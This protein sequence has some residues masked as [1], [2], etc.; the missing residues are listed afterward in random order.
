MAYD[1][2]SLDKKAKILPGVVPYFGLRLKANLLLFS[3][4]PD[5]LLGSFSRIF[6]S[7]IWFFLYWI[8]H[9]FYVFIICMPKIL[10]KLFFFPCSE[11]KVL[12]LSQES[13]HIIILGFSS[14]IIT[15][16]NIRGEFK[17]KTVSMA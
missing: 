12:K 15:A 9:C 11:G 8:S 13:I 3:P 1:V 7:F 4:K 17:Y 2:I 10:S 16:D 14:A 6:R 5:M